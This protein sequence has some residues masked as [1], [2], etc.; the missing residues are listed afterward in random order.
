[1]AKLTIDSEIRIAEGPCESNNFPDMRRTR[2]LANA[3]IK[4]NLQSSFQ[5]HKERKKT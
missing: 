5:Q 4:K 1:M 2:K 3:V